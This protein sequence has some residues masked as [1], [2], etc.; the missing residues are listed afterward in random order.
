MEGAFLAMETQ[1]YFKDNNITH[2]LSLNHAPYAER[3]IRTIKHMIYKRLEHYSL[4]SQDLD[5]KGELEHVLTTFNYKMKSNV[6]K[7]TPAVAGDPAN[8]EKV[9]MKLELARKTTHLD[10]PLKVGDKVKIYKKKKTFDKERVP[11]WSPEVYTI[12]KIKDKQ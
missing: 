11:V 10:P 9:L 8:R 2:L 3:Y 4:T 6:T 5:W 12:T 7:L 1:K